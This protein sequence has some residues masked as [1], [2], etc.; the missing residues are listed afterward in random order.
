MI[1]RRAPKGLAGFVLANGSMS[2]SQS[3]EGKIRKQL[4]EAE[5]VDCMVAVP[6]KF[7][8]STQI[9]ACMSFLARGPRRGEVP[10]PDARKLRWLVGRSHRELTDEE[11]VWIAESFHLWR[12]G[13]GGYADVPEFCKSASPDEVRRHGYA[14]T[15]VRY[16]GVAPQENDG[17]PFEDNMEQLVAHLREQQAEGT[18]LEAAITENPKTPGF[19]VDR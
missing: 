2:S 3:G 17:E 19:G 8:Y 15:A 11:I 1:H 18:R 16:V 10:F 6:G 7:F 12:T 4:I 5:V 14:Q 9:L 13:D